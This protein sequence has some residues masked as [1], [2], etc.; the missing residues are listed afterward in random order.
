M[1]VEIGPGRNGRSGVVLNAGLVLNLLLTLAVA[2][3]V[4]VVLLRGFAGSGLLLFEEL[5]VVL[6]LRGAIRG[7]S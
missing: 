3:D 5:P 6:A 4:L 2:G 1:L 7:G